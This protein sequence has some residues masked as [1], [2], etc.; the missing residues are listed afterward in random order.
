MSLRLSE[1]R[2]SRLQGERGFSHEGWNSVT[3]KEKLEFLLVA[4]NT[5]AASSAWGR[6]S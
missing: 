5:T 6:V 1:Q 3:V 4:V 2:Q